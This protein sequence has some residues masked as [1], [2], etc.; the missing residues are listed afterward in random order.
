M[1]GDD[2]R[3]GREPV[4]PVGQVHRIAER[5][6]HERAEED[7]EP[8]EIGHRLLD[9]RQMER[10]PALR[11]SSA[12]WRRPRSRIRARGGSCPTG[13]RGAPSSPCRNRRA[14]RSARSPQSPAGT[15]RRRGCAR[16]IHSRTEIDTEMRISSP[17]MVGVPRLARW[18]CGPSSRIGWP[19]PCVARSQLMNHGPEQKADEQRGRARRAGAEADVADE[20]E[21]AGEAE[22]VGDHVEH[23]I[24]FTIR[25]TSLASPT[26]LD[27]LTSTASPGRSHPHQRVGRFIDVRHEIEGDDCRPPARRAAAFRRRSGSGGR[28]AHRGPRARARRGAHRYARRARASGRAPRSAASTSRSAPRL[29]RV[30]AIDAGLAL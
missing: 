17:P 27:A 19:L 1:R 26:E 20:V 10:G 2:H 23:G 21:D 14:S 22:L 6:D 18:L 25:S 15:P 8:A 9:E 3:H 11:G 30:A 7:V 5:D 4:E 16:F 13:R 29:L 28:R 24:P 12:R